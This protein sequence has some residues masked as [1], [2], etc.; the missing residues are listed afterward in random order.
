MRPY[1]LNL[2][3][4]KLPMNQFLFKI[5]LCIVSIYFFPNQIRW[6]IRLFIRLFCP[7]FHHQVAAVCFE[8]KVHCGKYDSDCFVIWDIYKLRNHDHWLY[9]ILGWTILG[10]PEV[11]KRIF[12]SSPRMQNLKCFLYQDPFCLYPLSL[13]KYCFRIFKF[14]ASEYICSLVL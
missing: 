7:S 11:L 8:L 4:N 5:N 6:L 3:E 13:N 12:F 2:V 14:D 1:F 9:Q 10:Y